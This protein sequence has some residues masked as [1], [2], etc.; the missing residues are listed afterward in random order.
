MNTTFFLSQVL[1]K[2]DLTSVEKIKIL[3]DKLKDIDV[4]FTSTISD[5]SKHHQ[6]MTNWRNNLKKNWPKLHDSTNPDGN[7]HCL[8]IKR[9][10]N[11][12]GIEIGFWLGEDNAGNGY[13][14]YWG[15]Y[16]G[17]G[18]KPTQD[19][20]DMVN[21]ILNECGINAI[22]TNKT[23]LENGWIAWNNF[24]GKNQLTVDEICAAIYNKAKELGYLVEE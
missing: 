14:P 13:I 5:L 20:I 19:Q 16:C 22:N 2:T 18:H 11:D 12:P 17:K 23:D 1:A 15:A 6:M 24:N 4:Q 3:A 8:I 7:G 9:D 10:E 21:E